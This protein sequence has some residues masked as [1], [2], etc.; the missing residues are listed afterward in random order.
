MR[1]LDIGSNRYTEVIVADDRAFNANHEYY[2]GRSD[3]A[4]PM[5]EF[6]RIQFQKG[7]VKEYDVNG[8]HNEDLLVIVLDRLF[9][10]QNSE[11]NCIEN[12]TAIGK[13]EEALYWL[14]LRTEDRIL[15]G[16]EGKNIK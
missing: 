7:P 14:N 9:S 2:L 13:I 5:G 1:K 8:C 3:D 11:F 12:A 10:F 16:V 6:G 4:T 15:R